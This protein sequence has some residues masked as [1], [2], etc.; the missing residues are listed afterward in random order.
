MAGNNRTQVAKM[1][2]LITG[3]NDII[4]KGQFGRRDMDKIQ[5]AL[6]HAEKGRAFYIAG[7]MDKSGLHMSI[8]HDFMAEVVRTS[9]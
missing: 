4:K 1:D 8:A 7:N 2:F 9:A 6:E 3:L 5:I